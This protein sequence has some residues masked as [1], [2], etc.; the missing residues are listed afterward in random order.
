MASNDLIGIAG[1]LNTNARCLSAFTTIQNSL[2]TT[3]KFTH[4]IHFP[5]LLPLQ[6]LILNVQNLWFGTKGH[7][8]VVHCA[9][10]YFAIFFGAIDFNNTTCLWFSPTLLL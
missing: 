4:K 2:T 3:T 6:S 9:K 5:A 1:T 10:S 7:F 8:H